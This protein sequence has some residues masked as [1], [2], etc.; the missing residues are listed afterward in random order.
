MSETTLRTIPI[1]SI[2]ENPAALRPVD[3]ENVQ[4]KE[5]V[6]SVRAKG[7]L[8]TIS[9]REF[10]DA[11]T[12]EIYYS[13]VDGLQRWNAALDAG[14]KE[15]D[16]K[17]SSLDDVEALEHQIVLNATRVE[18]KPVEYTK[19]IHR[20]LSMNPTLTIPQ[21]AGRL[22]KSTTWLNERMNLTKLTDEIGA[23]VDAGQLNITNAYALSKLP[24]EDQVGYLDRAISL[25]PA[26][27]VGLAQAR[28]KEIKDQRRAGKVPGPATWEPHPYL[29]KTGDIKAEV[30]VPTVGPFLIK[31]LKI[32]DPAEAFLMGLKWVLHMDPKSVEQQYAKEQQRLKDADEA[33]K[34]RKEEQQAK[35]RKD[36]ADKAEVARQMLDKMKTQPVAV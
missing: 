26:E 17:I 6:D 28:A 5:L 33:K 25:S 32:T 27:F 12:G 24:P 16:V 29:Q 8:Q 20:L 13:L 19:A 35:E 21:L 4:Y 18:T 31:E 14:L 30:S 22:N 11:A 34:K 23:L 3:R 1:S 7:V 36:A 10:K 9:V 2:R 15:I